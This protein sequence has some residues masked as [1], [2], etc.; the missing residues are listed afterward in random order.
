MGFASP[1][2]ALPRAARPRVIRNEGAFA[3]DRAVY[4]AGKRQRHG[5]MRIMA[6]GVHVPRGL[7][8]CRRA[9][10]LRDGKGVHIRADGDGGIASGIKVRAHAR[11]A[12]LK[13]LAGKAVQMV[14]DVLDG[15][16][17]FKI[18]LRYAVQRLTMATQLPK[19]PLR[20][21]TRHGVNGS[22]KHP[23]THLQSPFLIRIF[24]IACIDRTIHI[25]C[26]IR[27]SRIQPLPI[28]PAVVF[29]R[30]ATRGPS[31]KRCA[32]IRAGARTDAL[33][34]QIVLKR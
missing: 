13:D 22:A 28:A 10:P 24:P 33:W 23:C 6:A 14:T 32:I 1:I 31:A 11:A 19:N 18:E 15:A 27:S 30:R 20:V 2:F 17:K 3:S 8:G 21:R 7:R 29:I 25:G 5:H 26:E 16:R 12:G 4:H 9:G 34:N